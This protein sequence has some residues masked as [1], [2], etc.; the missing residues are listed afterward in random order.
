MIIYIYNSYDV[1]S[2]RIRTRMSEKQIQYRYI[3]ANQKQLQLQECHF[4]VRYFNLKK[5]TRKIQRFT[6]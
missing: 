3:E 4:L 6:N 2:G 1:L 5:Q